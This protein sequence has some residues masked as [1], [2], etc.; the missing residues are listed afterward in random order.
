MKRGEAKEKKEQKGK[1]MLSG[2]LIIKGERSP[3]EGI[4]NKGK[5]G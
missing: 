4:E 2:E 1:E 5:S 3:N